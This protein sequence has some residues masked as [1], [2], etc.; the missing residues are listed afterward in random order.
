M[1]AAAPEAVA[2]MLAVMVHRGPD[3]A[4]IWQGDGVVLG[5]RRLSLVDLEGGH[6]PVRSPDGDHVLVFN[7][8]I[9]NHADLRSDLAQLGWAFRTH[10]DSE[11]LLAALVQWGEAALPLLN[12]MFSIA[13]WDGK[14]QT[15]TLVRDRM[16]VKPLYWRNDAHG[17]AFASEIKA[18]LAGSSPPPIRPQ[19]IWDYLTLRYVPGPASIWDGI[20]KLQ[21][22]HLLTAGPDGGVTIRRWWDIPTQPRRLFSRRSRPS[23]EREFEHCFLDAVR[24]RLL[25]DVPVGILLSGGLDSSAVAAAAVEV[26]GDRPLT[27][28][29][30]FAD[31]TATD[32]RPY[33]REVASH[34]G[35]RHHEV[36]VEADQFISFLPALVR[37]TDE[38]LADLASVPL[39]FVCGLARE[40]GCKAVLSGEGADEILA[41][42][43]FDRVV[44]D[45]QAARPG[46]WN[47]LTGRGWPD[48]RTM[49]PPPHMTNLFDSGEKGRL[50]RGAQ[51]FPDTLETLAADLQRCASRDPLDQ[52]LFLYCQSWLVEDLLMKADKMSMAA[53]V[54]LRTPFLD[55]RLVE[56]AGGAPRSAKVGPGADGRLT[57]KSILRSFAASRLPARILTRPKQG[58][59]VPV[60]QW[61]SGRLRDWAHDLLGSG[62]RLR[63]W[64][65]GN[66]LDELLDLGTAEVAESSDRHRLWQMLVLET[67]LLEWCGR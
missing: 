13:W 51:V 52:M 22:A 5:M 54:E 16:G 66:A 45:W 46:W 24:L 14:R 8:E 20:Q 11:V 59:P 34:L 53:S 65:D 30:A 40:H 7:G 9:Y 55:Y 12:G 48:L 1:D 56:W 43:D 21:P 6:Q 64:I 19:A 41:G 23:L 17:L 18:L 29:V 3:D 36:V 4:G 35:L 63:S 67:W 47:R 27:F 31:S 28:S 49:H 15:L 57:T 50:L 33:A 26:G 62:A 39:H 37:A 32:E 2:G 10:S 42:Y 38:P 44:R 61:L 58:F 60:Y 25:A